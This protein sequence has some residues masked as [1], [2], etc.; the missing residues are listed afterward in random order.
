LSGAE[1]ALSASQRDLRLTIDT[2]PALVWSTGADGSVDFVNQHYLD[3]V[4][5]P[6]EQVRDWGWTAAVHP[7][8]LSGLTAIWR[9]LIA[10]GRGGEVEARFRRADGEYRWLLVRA[11]PLHDGNGNIVKWYGLN[12]DIEDRR[13]AEIHLAGEK[14]V[15]EM[16][17]S[18]RPLRDVLAALCR[19]FEEAASDC[20]CGIYPIDGRGKT[21]EFGV[22]PSLPASYTDPI[23]GAQVGSDDS[24][25]GQSISEK[26]QVIAEDIES[27]PRWIQAPCRGHVLDHGLRAVWSTPI[28]SREGSIIG[29]ICVYQQRPGRPSP[30]HQEIIAHVAQLASIAIER[31]QAE[32]VL[33]RSEFYLT[34]G[35][36]ISLTGTFAF[37]ED[38]AR[39]EACR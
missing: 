36:R 3:Y 6:L 12:T 37:R 31:S 8:D 15:L 22:A 16:I 7:D 11:N 23:E 35:Q 30:H 18:G 26:T 38:A 32:D 13:R 39:P 33:K 9:S 1:Q 27:D 28:C 25:R 5:L 29:T 19:L 20:F 14:H 24:P 17:A 10:S 34:Q 2:I 21:F 4:G